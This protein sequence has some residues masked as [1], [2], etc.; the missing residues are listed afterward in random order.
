MIKTIKQFLSE[1]FLL[2]SDIAM[3]LY[4]NYAAHLPIVDFHNHLPVS[5]IACNRKFQ[6]ITDLWLTGDHYKWRAMR[7]AGVPEEFCSGKADAFSKFLKWADTV[8]YTLRNPLYHWT[9][10][11]LRCYFG[12][13]KLLNSSNAKE[14]YNT[15]N[16]LLQHDEFSVQGLLKKMNVEII[17]TTDDPADSLA[18]HQY[19]KDNPIGIKVLPTFRPDGLYRFDYAELYSG[20][21]NR[22][23]LSAGIEI[24]SLDTLLQAVE[25]R[26]NAFQ[27]A[28]C[29]ASDHGLAYVPY[30]PVTQSKAEKIFQ[31][32]L[33]RKPLSKLENE[34]L[35][36]YLLLSLSEMYYERK[37]V[38]QFHL[39]AMRNNN[40][41]SLKNL[42]F[43]AGFDSIGDYPQAQTLAQFL[44]HLHHQGKLSKTVLYNLNPA[45]NEVFASM[46]GNFND[47]SEPGKIQ[48]G[49]AWWFLDQ[50]DGIER[51]LNAL[52][53]LGLLWFFIGMVTDSRS[54]L[55]FP[56]HDY[57]RRILCNILGKEIE[58]GLLPDDYELMKKLIQN[59]CYFNA[60]N[61]FKF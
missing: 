26:M 5:D 17:C 46:T 11:E 57:F 25:I 39:G 34:Q 31:S 32:A 1:D 19:I 3:D 44:N 40:H 9:H 37:W 33:K 28:G 10:M 23:G 2:D 55:S 42:G 56:R 52:S 35:T 49:A 47:E 38:Q 7:T 54:F 43:D 45:D 14:I 12:I 20:Y 48:Y 4:H 50:K 6:T 15:I 21:I 59:V 27:Q 22:L 53:N 30:Q 16:A 41:R 13:N 60:G 18:H 58:K 51:H 36:T 24:H 8:P 61:Y 29:R